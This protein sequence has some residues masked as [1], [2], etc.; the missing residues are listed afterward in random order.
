MSRQRLVN[1]LTSDL[2]GPPEPL[3][4]TGARV[5]ELFQI[6]IVRDPVDAPEGTPARAL[7]PPG[8]VTVTAS[9]GWVGPLVLR[10]SS[11]GGELPGRRHAVGTELPSR[12]TSS[13]G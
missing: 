3:R 13:D 10:R 12:I 11:P 7:A 8:R 1:L 2:P 6:G 4:L 9:V 5:L